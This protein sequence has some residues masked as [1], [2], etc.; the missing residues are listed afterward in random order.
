[1]ARPSTVARTFLPQP[2]HGIPSF[3]QVLRAVASAYR[4]RTD[5]VQAVAERMVE[6]M[7]RDITSSLDDVGGAGSR[8]R[9]DATAGAN[10]GRHTVGGGLPDD[11]PEALIEEALDRAFRELARGFD[12]VHGGF[13]GAPKFPRPLASELL[14]RHHLRTGEGSSL[15]MAVHTLRRMA[16]G[17]IRDHLA[18]G[19]HRYSVDARWLVPHF[20]K[21]LYDN[22]LLAGAYLDAFRVT[23][24]S[25]LRAV[26][27]ET[28]DYVM[29]DLS[30][31]EGGFFA[32][33]DAD[34]EGEEGAYY[35]W[36]SSEIDEVLGP[37]L[38]ELFKRVHDVSQVGNFEGRNI[39]HLPHDPGAVAR[40]LGIP[41]PELR[42]SMAEARARLRSVRD[43]RPEPFRDEKVIV[44]WASLAIRA[45][46]EAAA[47]LGRCDYREMATQ[48]A[49]FVWTEMR[50]GGK[51][52][53]TWM[54]GRLGVSGF[55]EDHAA[56]A[57]ALLSVHSATLDPYW[58][59]AAAELTDAMLGRFA[60]P[61]DA[62]VFFDSA[63]DAE[64]AR[65]A[66]AAIP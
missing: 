58:L 22:A 62:G 18:G 5:E 3:R 15:E 34:S 25:D 54:G 38:A 2:R 13:G 48:G 8:T 17:G 33:R 19:F 14:L 21:M 53:R 57:N 42:S 31:G 1:M 9:K 63:V 24:E 20:E 16:A 23:G 59:K 65:R 35:V 46:A 66:A 4:E 28:L 29:A 12:P 7:A 40:S 41:E 56:L 44:A 50:P 61:E 45:F 27:E 39:L 49:H 60:D 55:L 10:K 43:R 6:A 32:A 47:T 26:C 64:A 37:E 11:S 30:S 51:L 36:R 52:A